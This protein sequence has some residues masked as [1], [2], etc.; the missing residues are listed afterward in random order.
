MLPEIGQIYSISS[1]FEEDFSNETTSTESNT[2]STYINDHP[3]EKNAEETD[4]YSGLTKR[5]ACQTEMSEGKLKWT[6]PVK[7]K[8]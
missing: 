8:C 7:K 3:R 6:N 4:I 1:I 5:N 2:I